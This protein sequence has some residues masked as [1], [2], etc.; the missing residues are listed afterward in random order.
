MVGEGCLGISSNINV[1]DQSRSFLCMGRISTGV[2]ALQAKLSTIIDD[3]KAQLGLKV[4]CKNKHGEVI[5]PT[6]AMNSELT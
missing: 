6:P 1:V 5:R 2:L 3:T 4:R